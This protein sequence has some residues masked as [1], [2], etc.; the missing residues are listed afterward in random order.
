M[1]WEILFTTISV[2]L[3]FDLLFSKS[4]SNELCFSK[5]LKLSAFFISA[6]LS[7]GIY[8]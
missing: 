1:H 3:S 2:L 5:S 6:G 8:I 4:K 7:F